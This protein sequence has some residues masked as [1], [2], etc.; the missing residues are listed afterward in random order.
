MTPTRS[1]ARAVSL[2]VL[3]SPLVQSIHKLPALSSGAIFATIAATS[4]DVGKHV[5]MTSARETSESVRAQRVPNAAACRSALADVRFHT[6][7]GDA[8][9][10]LAAAAARFAAMPHPMAPRPM[11]ATVFS[12]DMRYF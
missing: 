8:T 10:P 1:S 3:G 6:V 4:A 9:S 12:L 2:V 7:T 11:K 5:M